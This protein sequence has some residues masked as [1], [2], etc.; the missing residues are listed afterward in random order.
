[1]SS[2]APSC[3]NAALSAV[4]ACVSVE[5]NAPTCSTTSG[6]A[7]HAVARSRSRT[8]AGSVSQS[9][10]S[11]EKRPLTNTIV[12]QSVAPNMNGARSSRATSP[13]GEASSTNS[14]SAI[15]ETLV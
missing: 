15:G 9:D 11:R 13:L 14:C 1:M 10:S 6:I 7:L 4:N 5:T 12:C 8:P 3:M 2:T